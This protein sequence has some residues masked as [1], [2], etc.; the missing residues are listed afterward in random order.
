MLIFESLNQILIVNRRWNGD[1]I[2]GIYIILNIIK[3][4]LSKIIR[5]LKF[6]QIWIIQISSSIQS[7]NVD[8]GLLRV[9]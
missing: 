5:P 4:K 6:G 1:I 7:T 3:R 9:F 8:A 2:Y